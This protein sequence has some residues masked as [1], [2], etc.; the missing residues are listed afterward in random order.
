MHLTPQNEQ[1]M[2]E[3]RILRLKPAFRLEWRGQNGQDEAAQSEYDPVKLRDCGCLAIRM[4]FSVHIGGKPPR[5]RKS[6]RLKER[7]VADVVLIERVSR[8]EIPAIRGQRAGLAAK[9]RQQSSVQAGPSFV[10]SD[11]R[12]FWSDGMRV[13]LRRSSRPARIDDPMAVYRRPLGACRSNRRN[14][15]G[16]RQGRQNGNKSRSWRHLREDAEHV[17]PNSTG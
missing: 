1:L 10:T 9:Q 7:V 2:S 13:D 17:R 4:R 16:G 12:V 11:N 14:K 3:N 8:P 15:Q 5:A 6:L